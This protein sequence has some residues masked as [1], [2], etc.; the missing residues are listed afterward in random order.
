MKAIAYTAALLGLESVPVEIQ[1]TLAGAPGL[2]ITG[3]SESS[4]RE[5]RVRV[6]ASLASLLGRPLD[7]RG[8]SVELSGAHTSGASFDLAIA[9]AVLEALGEIPQGAL[10]DT[11]LLGELSF[12]GEIR[13]IRG[14]LPLLRGSARPHAIVPLENRNQAGL[15]DY[16][17]PETVRVAG[18]LAAV[19]GW[20]RGTGEAL[21][22]ATFPKLAAGAARECPLEITRKADEIIATGKRRVLLVGPPGCGKTLL[23]RALAGRLAPMTKAETLETLTIFGAAGILQDSAPDTWLSRPFRA[24]HHSVSEAGL[25]GGGTS[26]RPG[27]ASLAGNGVLFLDEIGEFR[28]SALET[29]F[30]VLNRGVSR[31]AASRQTVSFP[32]CPALVVGAMPACACGYAGHPRIACKCPPAS[33]ERYAARMAKIAKHFDITLEIAPLTVGEIMRANPQ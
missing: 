7:G 21:G 5:S 29:L 19:V 23:A 9:C 17:S 2:T 18:S 16:D 10:S 1:A 30:N 28:T 27:E 25:V 4:A 26:P 6:A 14:V 12:S 24:P 33:R 8:V 11:L 20:F 13:P 31:L 3:L 32:A 15:A 22:L